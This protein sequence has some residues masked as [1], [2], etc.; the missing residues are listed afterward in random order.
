MKRVKMF[1]EYNDFELGSTED[2]LSD[3]V[4]DLIDA[5]LS[6]E[7][8]SDDKFHV[9]FYINIED[10]YKIFCKEYPIND[11]DWLYNK[12]IMLEFYER[13]RQFGLK[14]DLDFKIY[15][16]GLVVNLVFEDKYIVS[17]RYEEDKKI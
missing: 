11:M 5:G 8:K 1:N 9:N 12:P 14:R 3:L 13:L 7:F 17:K 16:G 6:V 2:I 10:T 4:I 15:G